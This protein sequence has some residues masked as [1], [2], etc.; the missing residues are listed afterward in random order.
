MQY[1]SHAEQQLDSHRC[2]TL[3]TGI[4]ILLALAWKAGKTTEATELVQI[5]RQ[6]LSRTLA[7]SGTESGAPRHVLRQQ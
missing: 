4:Y 1:G 2:V 3:P 6:T 7:A 5:D